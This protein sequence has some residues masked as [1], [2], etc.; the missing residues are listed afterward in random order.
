[1]PAA[2]D[3]RGFLKASGALVVTFALAPFPGDAK[4]PGVR[5]PL[6]VDHVD[7]FLA[8]DAN[9]KVTVYS[10]KVDLGTG[11]RTALSQI[12]AD[13]LDVPLSDVLLIQGDTALTPDQGVTYGSLSIQNGGVQLRHAAATARQ[14]LLQKASSKLKIDASRLNIDAG[15]VI[16]PNGE[17]AITVET[18]KSDRLDN[19]RAFSI[20]ALDLLEKGLV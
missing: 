16:G 15:I 1:M 14:A 19:M 11:V 2:I 12:V 18:G 4:P 9:G 5:K 8:I 17:R 13:E 7:S 3:R 20:A 10:G 6:D